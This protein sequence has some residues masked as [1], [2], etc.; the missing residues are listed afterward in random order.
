MRRAG[1]LAADG[2]AAS[3]EG[4]RLEVR[5]LEIRSRPSGPPV[6]SGIS[7]AVRPGEVLGL[8]GES[9]SG[10]TTVALALLGHTRRGPVREP[11][12]RSGWT[13][14]TCSGCAR[15]GLRALRGARVSYVPQD[16][17]A[18]LNPALRV[19][20]QLS[21][22]LRV[23]LP[24]ADSP[25]PPPVTRERIREV[26]SRGVAWTPARTC[27]AATRISCPA[28]S[29]S[30]S[31]LAMAFACRPCADRAGR[32]D[33]R[34]RRVDPAARPRHRPA[35]C[36]GATGSRP[37]YVSH[38]LAV[39]SELADEVAVMYAGRIV[40]AGPSRRAVR[41]AA[42]PL[43]PGA[44]RRGPGTGQRPPAGRD[45]RAAAAARPPRPG[46]RVRRPLRPGPGAVPSARAGPDPAAIRCAPI[47][48][49]HPPS[50]PHAAAFIRLPCR[51]LPGAR[52]R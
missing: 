19:G 41:R 50:T 52:P 18:A 40:E 28:A 21:E 1:E 37:S 3:P 24:A 4:F 12:A 26:L 44:A 6:V 8:V 10:K 5:D 49:P 11:A 51:A 14:P 43:Y 35:A 9:G 17:S 2:P 15:P 16:P 46:L 48:A 32:A 22:V 29:S 25:V 38:D 39:V 7:F 27:C 33:H 23:H 13:A 42:A 47:G 20:Y 34:P 36:A 30:A 45:T 31:A